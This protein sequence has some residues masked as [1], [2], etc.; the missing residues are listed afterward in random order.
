MPRRMQKKNDSKKVSALCCGSAAF[1][2]GVKGIFHRAQHHKEASNPNSLRKKLLTMLA[3]FSIAF[4]V[5]QPGDAVTVHAAGSEVDAQTILQEALLN[6]AKGTPSEFAKWGTKKLIAAALNS[7]E[8]SDCDIIMG[9]LDDIVKNQ[10]RMIDMLSEIDTKIMKKDLYDNMNEF[11]KKSWSGDFEKNYKGL[12]AVNAASYSSDAARASAQKNYLITSVAEMNPSSLHGGDCQFDKDVYTYGNYLTQGEWV[13]YSS[14]RQPIYSIWHQTMKYKYKWEH[15]SYEEWAAFQNNVTESYLSAAAVDKLSILARIDAIEKYNKTHITS[16][17]STDGLKTRLS[18]LDEQ[19]A[20]VREIY[21]KYKVTPLADSIR[22]YQ[23]PGHEMYLYTTAKEQA[24]INE[25]NRKK[26]IHDLVTWYNKH[27]NNKSEYTQ[28]TGIKGRWNDKMHRTD[29]SP[30]LNHWR[31]FISYDA[32][33]LT[34]TAEWMQQIYK[35]YEGKA[36]L[37]Q[38]FFDKDKGNLTPP[39]GWQKNWNFVV[40]PNP[41]HPMEYWDGGTFKADRIYTPTLNGSAAL[42]KSIIYYYHNWNN[43]PPDTVRHYI[44]IGITKDPRG[45]A[46]EIS[47]DYD[48][49]WNESSMDSDPQGCVIGAS[50]SADEPK[51]DETSKVS[52]S[53]NHTDAKTSP[54]TGDS[55]P[56][57][58][59]AGLA[60]LS[61]LAAAGLLIRRKTSSEK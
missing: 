21:N 52:D 6:A 51:K 56:I 57:L 43:N 50:L 39:S 60:F 54:E 58:P 61:A 42:Q 5:C 20:K 31:S 7:D 8:V 1:V 41:D 22:H 37:Y 11:I 47:P 46:D 49:I 35:D 4:T 25:A 45:N 28:L 18:M 23:V 27:R 44:G 9:R 3:A 48:D 55:A 36:T 17:I 53:L 32:S 19:I 26:G 29:V 59:L 33:T 2:K 15:Q 10:T 24:I 16:R 14:E 38:I 30:N 12:T 34:P 13:L 40:D